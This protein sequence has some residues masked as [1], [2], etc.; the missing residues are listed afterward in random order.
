M[1]RLGKLNEFYQ[2]MMVDEERYPNT[3]EPVDPLEYARAMVYSE[4]GFKNKAYADP[5]S[6]QEIARRKKQEGWENLSPEPVTIGAG[7]T[8]A[9]GLGEVKMGDTTTKEAEDELVTKKLQSVFKFMKNTGLQ[10]NPG[11]AS[12]I[13]NMGEGT[14]SSGAL[15]ELGKQGKWKEFADKLEEYRL[16]GG[17][18]SKGLIVRRRNEANVVRRWNGIEEKPELEY[19]TVGKEG[20][21]KGIVREKSSKKKVYGD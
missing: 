9:A 15:P 1:N 20:A 12:A 6:K 21:K 16:A 4:E 2:N 14:F 18:I 13:Y 11:I 19:V 7:R 8:T 3:A 5:Y 17:Q 10:E